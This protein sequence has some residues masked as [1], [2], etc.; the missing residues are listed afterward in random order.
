MNTSYLTL[1]TTRSDLMPDSHLFD[2]PQAMAAT[3]ARSGA[4]LSG[5][6]NRKCLFCRSDETQAPRVCQNCPRVTFSSGEYSEN[7][8]RNTARTAD[9]WWSGTI[10]NDP[11]ERSSAA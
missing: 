5:R 8:A 2:R 11:E 4:G 3:L 1:I 10:N 6:S 9:T 7:P